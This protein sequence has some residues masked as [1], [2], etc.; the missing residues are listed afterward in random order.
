MK[1]RLSFFFFTLLTLSSCQ[2]ILDKEPLGILDADS[3]LKT[4]DDAIQT[5]NAAY[6][7]LMFNNSNNNFYWAFAEVTSDEAIA[8]GDGSRAGITELE[9]FTYTPR[10]AEFNEFWKINYTGISQCNIVI[11]KVPF[12][13]MDEAVKNRILGD[14]HCLCAY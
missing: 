1:N 10:T 3:F 14:A 4:A 9:F 2:G 13:E 5:I 7:P 11:D 8:G 6:E 12:I